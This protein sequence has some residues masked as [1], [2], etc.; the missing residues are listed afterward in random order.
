[1]TDENACSNV[2]DGLS[3]DDR[4]LHLTECGGSYGATRA[5][6]PRGFSCR[7]SRGVIVWRGPL[8]SVPVSAALNIIHCHDDDV[9]EILRIL[10]S[11][12]R[13]ETT[14]TP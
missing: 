1:M 6:M 12:G 10:I 11:V 2:F 8:S 7:N 13:R 4:R 3:E 14:R 9:H 5:N